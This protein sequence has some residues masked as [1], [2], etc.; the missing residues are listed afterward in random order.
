MN[1]QSILLA[2][3]EP[4]LAEIVKESLESRG[5]RV[6]VAATVHETLERY[7]QHRPDIMVV[8]VMLADG[9][10]FDLVKQI[11]LSNYQLPVIFLTSRSHPRDVVEGFESGGNDYVKKPFSMEELIVRIRALLNIN[12]L[13]V[14]LRTEAQGVALGNYW[15]E[16][17]AGTL[18]F[19]GVQRTLTTRESEILKILL[20]HKNQVI[21]RQKILLEIW[22]S[23][24]FFTGRSLDVF[25]AKLR[26][27]LS[28]DASVMILNIR[29]QGYKLV[30]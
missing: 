9:S 27:Y 15:F 10:G 17:P 25:I 6:H 3:D 8:D 13:A 30:Y 29:G 11:R 14:P 24:D 1:P 16:Y 21:S 28:Q 5:Y 26:K 12:R 7:N 22:G 23:D 19:M 4:V 18:T 20:V 2:E